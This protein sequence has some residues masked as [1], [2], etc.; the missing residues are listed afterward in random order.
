MH[1]NKIVKNVQ[2]VST[3]ILAGGQG[4]RLFP[5]TKTRCKPAVVFGG[6]YRLIDVPI[7]N[8]LNSR[9][10]KIFVISQYFS[11]SLNEH[12][13]NTFSL[14]HFQGSKIEML[15]PEEKIDKK[16]WYEG[17][18]DAVRKN[19]KTLLQTPTEYF[20][21]LSGDQLYN[22]DLS[23]MLDFAQKHHADLTVAT[24]PVQK[25][26]ASRMGILKINED[27]EIVDF[28]EKPKDPA[29]LMQYKLQEDLMPKELK[30]YKAGKDNG[31]LFLASMG[32]YV[33]KR[34]AL[35]S[36]LEED[37]REDFGKHLIPTQIKK[38]RSYAFC[39]K[40]YWEDIGTIKSFYDANLA[41]TTNSI[42]LNLYSEAAPIYAQAQNLPSSRIVNTKMT[43]SL[44]CEGSII[45]ADEISHSMIGL[46]SF[47]DKGTVIK[48]SII[49]GNQYYSP[50]N[51]NA[52]NLPDHFGI[53]KN[54]LI[55]NAIIDEHTWVGDNVKLTNKQGL[56]EYEGDGIY[57]RDGIIVVPAGT[58][59][60]NG[61]EL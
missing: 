15:T 57:I 56:Q 28:V 41:L 30:H 25:K 24:L 33:F 2:K 11:Q 29:V 7:S 10:R 39:H 59:L 38:G 23:S 16:N 49:M 9:L 43:D 47:I 60:P 20:L 17:T 61:F 3:I 8:S 53:G 46:R 32:I 51:Q 6:R 36:L 12:I 48:D 52:Q 26:D 14:D 37:P 5:L 40:G 18:A 13:V 35:I 42:D 50:P 19:L 31:A 58:E 54:C 4:T 44:I 45:F 55:Q 34:D 1:L 27:Q 21:I 22:M